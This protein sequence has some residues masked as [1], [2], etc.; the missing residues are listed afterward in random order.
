MPRDGQHLKAHQYQPALQSKQRMVTL[1]VK[2]PPSLMVKIKED[3]EWSSK[4]KLLAI[5][6]TEG[7]CDDILQEMTADTDADATKAVKQL[8]KEM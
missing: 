1:G 7:K 2:V 3:P 4:I 5:A 8:F 6:F